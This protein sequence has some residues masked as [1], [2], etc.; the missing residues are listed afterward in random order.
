MTYLLLYFS[1]VA[2]KPPYD[3]FRDWRPMGTFATAELCSAAGAQLGTY[4]CVR[5]Q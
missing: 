3:N 1:I 5:V 4:K 2:T